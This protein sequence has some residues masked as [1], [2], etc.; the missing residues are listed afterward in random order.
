MRLN[1]CQQSHKTVDSDPHYIHPVSLGQSPGYSQTFGMMARE[2]S[3]RAFR[4]LSF[5]WLHYTCSG[6]DARRWETEAGLVQGGS[7]SS[8][9][10]VVG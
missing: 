9:S 8:G 1:S 7:G 3:N 6:K 5:G 4:A 2:E 10:H